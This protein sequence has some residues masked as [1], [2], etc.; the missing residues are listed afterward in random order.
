MLNRI[1]AKYINKP[2]FRTLEAFTKPD[3]WNSVT[4]YLKFYDGIEA[5]ISFEQGLSKKDVADRLRGLADVIE[6]SK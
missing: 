4:V 1:Y 6:N 5:G 3:E 2:V